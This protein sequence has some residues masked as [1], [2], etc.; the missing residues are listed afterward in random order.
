MVNTK[1]VLLGE[2]PLGKLLV[3]SYIENQAQ[4]VKELV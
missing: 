3:L 1:H 4:R 2:A